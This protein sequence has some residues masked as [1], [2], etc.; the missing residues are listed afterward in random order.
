MLTNI[1]RCTGVFRIS[2]GR[3]GPQG[4]VYADDTQLFLSSHASDF[5]ASVIQGLKRFC[6]TTRPSPFPPSSPPSLLFLSPFPFSSPPPHGHNTRS[7]PYVTLIKPSPSLKVTHRSFRHDSPHLWNQLSTSLRIP[8]PNY[9]SPSQ[10][11]SFEHVGLTCY[12]VVSLFHS[13][14]QNISSSTSSTVVC[15]SVSD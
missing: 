5:Q 14:H 13:E 6:R 15:F 11:P 3:T 9:S 12:T 4:T 8:H 10:R 1:P 2:E 7:S